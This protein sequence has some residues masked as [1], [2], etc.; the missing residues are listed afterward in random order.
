MAFN[1]TISA[2]LRGRWLLNKQWAYDHLPLV[3]L[4]LQG[5]N[6]SFTEKEVV[7]ESYHANGYQG[8]RT[9]MAINPSTM[10]TFNFYSTNIAPGSVAIIPV[11]GPITKY[12]GECG[13]AGSL[14]LGN[15]IKEANR[16]DHISSIVFSIDT[17]GGE[18][19]AASAF[20]SEIANTNKPTLSFIHGMAASLGVFLTSATD[21]VYFADSQ[22]ELGSVG[23]YVTLPDFS[24]YFEKQGIKLHEIYAP[25]S[26]DK[27]KD[28]RDALQGDY[29]AIEADLEKHV[30]H[31]ISFVKTNR[32][33]KAAASVK[34]W[35]SGKLFSAEDAIKLGLADG[36]R[37]FNQ[38]VSKAAWLAKR[39][40]AA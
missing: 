35:N 37:P 30:N 40:K 19:R 28:Y 12:N 21:E 22:G 31:F 33:D 36:I 18:A 9:P 32:G 34:E 20:T 4:M 17:P 25:Q 11:S 5:N 39:A 1:H 10:E 16:R 38:V 8:I 7:K 29:S 2:I 6:I 13:E 24:G 3:L 14:M 27:N 26:T 15:W 23:S